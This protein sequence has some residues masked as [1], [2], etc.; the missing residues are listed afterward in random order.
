MKLIIV[1]SPAKCGK[2]ESF[3][4][5]GY[6]CLASFGHIREIANGL[7]SIDVNN[8]YQ[9]T[10]KPTRS[11]SQNISNLRKWIKKAEEVILA[12]DDDREGEAIA[13]HIC[14]LFNLPITTTK[15]IIFHEITKSALK[16]AVQNPTIVNMNT[17][18][19]QLARQVLDLMVGYKITPI[20]WK[21]ISRG[22]KL[23]AGRCQIPALRLVYDQQKL[24]DE[25]PGKKVYNTIGNFL[26]KHLDFTLNKHHN[27]EDSMVS[28]LEDSADFTHKYN[29]TE[30]RRVTKNP[31]VPF[32]TSTLQQKAS[33]HFGYSPKQTMRTA[34]NLYEGGY[35]TYMR[36]DSKTYS[37]EFVDITK[38][39]ISQ[40]YGKDYVGKHCNELI[41][42]N[43]SPKKAKK[44]TK[45]KKV[46]KKQENMAQE[47]HEAIRPTKIEKMNIKEGGKIGSQEIRLYNLIWKNTIESLMEKAIY[48]SITAEISA[49]EKS[50][51]KY[52][53]EKVIFKGWK[54]LEKDEE[55]LELYNYLLNFKKKT[56]VDYHKITSK[57]TLKDLKKN[58]T[59]AKLVQMLEKRGIG[60]PSTYSSL[61]SKIQERAYVLKQNVEGKK[62]KCVDFELEKEELTEIENE[63]VFGNEKNKL[64]IQETGKIVMEFLMK[65]FQ[66]LF[67]YDYTKTMEDSLDKIKEGN[68]VWHDLCRDC[69]KQIKDSQSKIKA[70][71]KQE[72]QIDETHTYMIGKYGPVIKQ[73]IDDDKV[74]FKSVK[75]NLDVNK[76]KNGEYTLEEIVEENKYTKNVLGE[77]KGEEVV[78]KKGKYGLYTTYNGKNISLK[79]ISKDESEITLQDVVNV[80]ENGIQ[81]R[82]KSIIREVDEEISIRKGKFGAYVFYKT[83]QMKKPKFCGLGKQNIDDFM[84]DFKT[85][86][87]LKDWATEFKPKKFTR[88]KK[89]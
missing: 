58:Y 14:K 85:P 36:T 48:E 80:L 83:K 84:K 8:N 53:I 51:Y 41:T 87:D 20:L 69:D 43:K 68:K 34:Q 37:K 31:P 35:I 78:L 9:V 47:A 46:T 82:N 73:T 74:V 60:R 11:K 62:I 22:S 16:N 1:E 17:V 2:I 55:D 19:A 76:L 38:K 88:G 67:S 40:K 33:N 10:F 50:K 72:F 28:F 7:K 4:G 23:S 18:N 63:R 13:W 54:I 3:L 21:N 65:H 44:K 39:F 45:G 79:S 32:T 42:N 24:I 26:D 5:T 66:E 30:P 27:T 6:K 15:R 59:E 77:H 49:P 56:K 12:T 70:A 86:Q 61:I 71:D 75:K 29:V 52:S 25:H 89:F 57:V 64:V 81:K